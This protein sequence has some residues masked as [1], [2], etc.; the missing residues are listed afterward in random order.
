MKN[1]AIFFFLLPIMLQANNLKLESCKIVDNQHISLTISWENSWNIAEPPA[2]H[3]A[4]WVFFKIKQQAKWGHCKLSGLKEEHTSG[5]QLDILT[6][7]DN[8]GLMVKRK[9]QGVGNVENETLIIKTE[10]S[11]DIYTTEIQVFGI[12]MIY[13]NEGQ[14][15]IGDGVSYNSFVEYQTKQAY[16]ISSEAQIQTGAASG[17][18]ALTKLYASSQPSH[19]IPNSYPKGFAGFYCMK[20]EITQK[21]YADFLNTLTTEQQKARTEQEPS[22]PRNTPCMVV[23]SILTELEKSPDKKD[24]LLSRNTLR[25]KTS[26]NSSTPATYGCNDNANDIFDEAMDGSWRAMNWLKWSDLA[27]YLDWAALCPMTELEFEKICRG[28]LSSVAG[29]FAWGTAFATNTNTL[30]DNALHSESINE[31]AEP[32]AGLANFGVIVGAT[33]KKIQ[34]PLRSGFAAKYNSDRISAGASYFGVMEMSGNVWEQVINISEKACSF[35]GLPGNGELSA[36]GFADVS[37]WPDETGVGAGF[38]GGGWQ[39]AIFPVGSWR[40]MAIS[41]RYYIQLAP[42]TRRNTA[43]GRGIRKL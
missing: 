32:N 23:S 29:E 17:N 37:T 27:A 16:K 18:L 15:F 9:N 21:Q 2:N 1:L 19:L 39:S 34:G 30:I 5:N 26:A 6:T 12:E 10:A 4:V 14:F 22:S 13:I 40:D 28:P 20:Y 7:K 8:T 3:D 41:D 42:S 24:S 25:T 35:D 11:F 36:S 43:G 33:Q 38:K 31:I